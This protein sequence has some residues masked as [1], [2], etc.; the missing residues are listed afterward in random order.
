MIKFNIYIIYSVILTFIYGCSIY[1]FSG[2]SISEDIKTVSINYVKN[3]AKLIQPNLSTLITEKLITK[4]QIETNLSAS[5]DPGG[6]I[7]FYGKI[8]NY[9]ISPVAINSTEQ[10]T[11][12]RLTIT[13]EI[14]F[15]NKFD[16]KENFNKTFSQ[17]I[18]FNSSDNF[19]DLEEDLCNVI[20]DDLI[21]DI[22]NFALMSW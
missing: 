1:S 14:I 6:D 10:A 22:F 8:I 9:T 13:V 16:D 3:E 19:S 12:N 4:C 15:I 2:I 7:N 18:D 5:T 17:Y 20:V 11:Q 21:D